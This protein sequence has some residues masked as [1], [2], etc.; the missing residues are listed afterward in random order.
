M[1]GPRVSAKIARLVKRTGRGE[2]AINQILLILHL[3]GFGAAVAASIA[4]PIVLMLMRAAP[5]DAPVLAK[6]PPRFARVGQVGLGLLWLTGI[7]MV[8]SKFGGPGGLPILFWWKLACVVLV[9]ITVAMLGI[10]VR[11]VQGGDQA[12]AA[13]LPMWG[14]ASGG[15]L[16]LIVILAVYAFD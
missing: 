5:G 9:T 12:A 8:W 10:T 13:R 6:L 16:V 1:R 15:L 3:F 11:R 4:G 2:A 14:A 7:I